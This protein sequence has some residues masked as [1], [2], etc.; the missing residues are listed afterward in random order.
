M[1]T[2]GPRVPGYWQDSTCRGLTPL[3]ATHLSQVLAIAV[4]NQTLRQNQRD[5]TPCQGPCQAG[6]GG[7]PPERHR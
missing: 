7:P 4:V 5:P 1:N 3:S 6:A 2:A